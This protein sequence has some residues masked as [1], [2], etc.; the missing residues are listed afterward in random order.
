MSWIDGADGEIETYSGLFYNFDEPSPDQISLTDIA[1]HLSKA[2]R[3]AGATM[4]DQSVADHSIIVAQIVLAGPEPWRAF[5]ALLHDG[6]EAYL[7]D[8]PR[9]MKKK[10]GPVLKELADIAD[11]SIGEK[12]GVDP[13]GFHHPIVKAADN[14]ALRHEAR[15]LMR[16]GGPPGEIEPLPE[17][18][19]IRHW[20][21]NLSAEI[22]SAL[23]A[24]LDP[25]SV[26][27]LV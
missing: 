9:P 19:Y 2:A 14:L 7:C 20:R 15:L 18:V 13:I 10:F 11:Q 6:H 26:G 4:S 23:A 5:E 8:I 17:G 27:S 12:F 16:S 1:H 21:P 22:F 3:F 24:E 25:R